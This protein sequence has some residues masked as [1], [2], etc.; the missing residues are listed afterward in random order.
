[1]TRPNPATSAERCSQE[2]W[3]VGDVLEGNEGYGPV[4]VR[5]TQIRET[6]VLG[7]CIEQSS[8][9]V[10]TSEQQWSFLHYSWHKIS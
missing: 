3:K 10:A 5:I 6:E 1:M 8:I 2:G 9:E 7:R 4:R